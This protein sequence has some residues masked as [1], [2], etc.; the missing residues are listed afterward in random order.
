MA[1]LAEADAFVRGRPQD[2]YGCLYYSAPQQRFVLP[3][4][5]LSLQEQDVVPHFG[6]PGGV[7]PRVADAHQD[8]HYRT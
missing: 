4:G 3:R 5:D 7:L 6:E 8:Y 1:A 2:E